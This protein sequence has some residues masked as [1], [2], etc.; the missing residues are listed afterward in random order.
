MYYLIAFQM[1]CGCFSTF[2]AARKGR[3]PILWWL[4]GA[5]L[6]IFGVVLSLALTAADRTRVSAGGREGA[7][8]QARQGQRIPRRCCGSYI[9]DCLGCPFFRRQL[10]PA[11]RG[12]GTRGYC[13]HLHKELRSTPER[14]G[15]KVTIE[16]R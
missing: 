10:F 4:V 15:S 5:L 13:D 7:P 9:P 8:E 6:P 12:E 1:L 11:G 16:D 14:R 2:V 3:N